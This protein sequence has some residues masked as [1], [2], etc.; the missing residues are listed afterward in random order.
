MAQ[1][2]KSLS[3]KSK[4]SIVLISFLCGI[5]LLVGLFLYIYNLANPSQNTY[6]TTSEAS[7][8]TAQDVNI[9]SE[10]YIQRVP[11][12]PAT[13]IPL[14]ERYTKYNLSKEEREKAKY[15]IYYVAQYPSLSGGHPDWTNPDT[16]EVIPGRSWDGVYDIFDISDFDEILAG[17]FNRDEVIIALQERENAIALFM[18]KFY[19]NILNDTLFGKYR[20]EIV[21]FPESIEESDKINQ[22]LKEQYGIETDILS[23]NPNVIA[24][25]ILIENGYKLDILID[26]NIKGST[27]PSPTEDGYAGLFYTLS[28]EGVPLM[29]NAIQR[30]D[31]ILRNNKKEAH[32]RYLYMNEVDLLNCHHLD[33]NQDRSSYFSYILTDPEGYAQSYYKLAMELAYRDIAL[34]PSTFAMI[35]GSYHP[36]NPKSLF[37]GDDGINPWIA[38]LAKNYSLTQS[39]PD[40]KKQY[41]QNVI[42]INTYGTAYHVSTFISQ[43]KEQASLASQKYGTNI[44]LGRVQEFGIL[45]HQPNRRDYDANVPIRKEEIKNLIEYFRSWDAAIYAQTG[46]NLAP[47]DGTIPDTLLHGQS[48]FKGGYTYRDEDPDFWNLIRSLLNSHITDKEIS[49]NSPSNPAPNDESIN[50][51]NQARQAGVYNTCGSK[52]W[53]GCYCDEILQQYVNSCG[54][55]DNEE[56]IPTNIGCTP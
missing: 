30:V 33:C 43:V 13:L 2:G 8:Y 56:F 14:E 34:A 15:A 10:R 24:A 38:A 46:P 37:S 45:P 28:D 51:S 19:A 21:D 35:W 48:G 22:K 17:G 41:V 53:R 42:A 29:A 31:T 49:N 4:N 3:H 11:N 55:Q 25:K 23:Q 54:E 32:I 5:A 20:I 27:L 44:I 26:R 47:W 1:L 7:E 12:S 16:G 18:N 6:T 39:L 50:C 9:L 36:D 40:E 52:K